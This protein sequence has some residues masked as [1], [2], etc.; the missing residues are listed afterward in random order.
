M[1]PGDYPPGT[2]WPLINDVSPTLLM[3]KTNDDRT[4]IL[5]DGTW[6]NHI[7]SGHPEMQSL[8]SHVEWCIT[9]PDQINHDVRNP[10]RECYYVAY[11]T[12]RGR[13]LW[14]KVVIHFDESVRGLRGVDGYV[15]TAHLCG[16]IRSKEV[17]KWP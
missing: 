8:L 12:S 14:I 7:V 17:K 11:T 4:V 16:R 1:N 3:C 6:N 13:D 15:V 5:T 9:R 10:Y 2:T